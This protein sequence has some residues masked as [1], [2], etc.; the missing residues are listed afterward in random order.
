MNLS[1]RVVF[2]KTTF[3]MSTLHTKPVHLQTCGGLIIEALHEL[4]IHP[5][6]V[7][8]HKE[9]GALLA[10]AIALHLPGKSAWTVEHAD[11]I[12]LQPG[13]EHVIKGENVLIVFHQDMDQYQQKSFIHAVLKTGCAIIGHV[14][15]THD[16]IAIDVA[17][18]HSQHSAL[19]PT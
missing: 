14:L 7:I 9:R 8:G 6:A 17:S 18:E 1:Q 12:V 4:R 5:T 15:I 16:G 10:H 11:G 13:Y 3:A 19:H 2:K